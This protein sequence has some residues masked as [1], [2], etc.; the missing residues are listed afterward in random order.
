MTK[1]GFYNQVKFFL[2]TDNNSV[3]ALAKNLVFYKRTKY[4]AVKYYYIRQFIKKGIIN[5]V[6]ISTKD[7]KSNSLTKLLNKTKFKEFLI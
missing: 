4:I 3:L 7:Q 5:L 6:Y 1:L 2:Y